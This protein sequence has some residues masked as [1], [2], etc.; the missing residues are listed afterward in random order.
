MDERLQFVARRLAGEVWRNFA[1]SSAFPARPATRS[2]IA[3]RNAVCKDSP[4][5]AVGPIAT[6]INFRSR[7]KTTSSM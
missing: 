4:I 2:S 3:I 7:W 1:G 5:A 6:L